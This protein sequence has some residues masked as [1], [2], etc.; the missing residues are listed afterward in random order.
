MSHELA[1]TETTEG[2]ALYR[3]SSDAASICK[4]IAVRTACTISG[5][6]YVKI[7]GWQAIATAHGCIL[8]ARD[9]RK[10][11]EGWTAIGEVR[12][13]SDGALLATAE[14]FVG[15]DE[16]V[17]A[18]GE[19][20]SYGK[21]K[22]YEKRPEYA[23]RAMAQTRACSR[24]ARS[25]FAHV[26]VM[27]DAGLET[28]PAEEMQGVQGHEEEPPLKSANHPKATTTAPGPQKAATGSG[29]R[30]GGAPKAPPQPKQADA[31]LSLTVTEVPMDLKFT[32]GTSKDGKPWEK[33]AYN[34]EAAGIALSTFEPVIGHLLD[35]ANEA[36]KSIQIRY[37]QED[38][39]GTP[40]GR[41]V[42]I[43]EVEQ[44]A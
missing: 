7:E 42:E 40:Y 33:W 10:T 12:R 22:K 21:L 41:I 3:R 15:N 39:K 1:K 44:P 16:P 8:S 37:T 2:A 43:V 32:H 27:M 31:N 36:G 4:D 9:V 14:G 25:A 6:K 28:T 19:V 29:N 30:A 26:V 13:I 18:G 17:W 24:V 38:Y 20:M 34:S 35:A 23:C 11:E 5:R